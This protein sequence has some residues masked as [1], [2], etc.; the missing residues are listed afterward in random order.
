MPNHPIARW[1]NEGGAVLPVSASGGHVLYPDREPEGACRASTAGSQPLGED[2]GRR[3]GH[4]EAG[5][6]D[7]TFL[8]GLPAADH[9]WI[10]PRLIA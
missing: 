6:R 2:G 1:E 10:N 3:P 5:D 7:V 4:G 9:G 8:S